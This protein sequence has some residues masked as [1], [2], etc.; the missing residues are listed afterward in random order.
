MSNLSQAEYRNLLMVAG[1]GRNSGKT[2]FIC[3]ICESWQS[4]L[5]LVCIKI[6]N[7]IHIEMG[8]TALYTSKPFN[9]YEETS[10]NS[11][12]DSSRM[13]QAGASH[14]FFIETKREF[15]SEAFQKVQEFI[16]ENAVIICESGT[17][18]RYIKPS[19]FIMLHTIGQEPK[20]SSADLMKI[21]DK[22]LYY[23]NGKLDISNKPVVYTSDTWKLNLE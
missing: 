9:I 2:S 20:E 22:I 17:L 13:L 1:T 15:T 16:P 11:D 12:K 21:A 4:D 18:R 3:K 7:H 10:K 5:P 14:V 6:S 19:L 8:I 23:E